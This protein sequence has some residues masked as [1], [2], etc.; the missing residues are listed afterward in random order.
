[1]R[2]GDSTPVVKMRMPVQAEESGFQ[3]GSK[4]ARW[5]L[6]SVV[7]KEAV[8]SLLCVTCNLDLSIHEKIE[9]LSAKAIH[10]R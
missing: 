9:L 10:V 5:D 7:L 6:C 8:V 4:K 3:S 2:P 1:M